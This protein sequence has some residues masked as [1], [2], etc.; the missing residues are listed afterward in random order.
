MDLDHL[1]LSSVSERSCKSTAPSR[2]FS[3]ATDCLS[4][5][6]EKVALRIKVISRLD[7]S[8]KRVPQ[9]GR[10]KLT[11]SKPISED[12]NRIIMS[13]GNAID[14]AKQAEKEGIRNLR[15]SGLLKVRQAMTSLEDIEAVTNE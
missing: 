7:I 15:Q 5:C 11:I 10:M 12:M 4:V 3:V 2:C 8:E 13:N 1:P 9:D 6:Q 14:I